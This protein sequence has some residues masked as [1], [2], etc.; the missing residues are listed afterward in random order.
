MQRSVRAEQA[1]LGAVLSDPAG[2]QRVLDWVR[3]GDMRRPYHG[4][5][6]A[7]MQ[8][9]RGGGV[10]PGPH[11]VRR[12]LGNDPDLR[13]EAS[14]RVVYLAELMERSPRDGHA[15]AYAALV[16][17]QAVHDQM[18]LAGSRMAQAAGSGN[19]DGAFVQARRARQELAAARARWE[20][21]PQHLRRDLP[22]P[23]PRDQ[24]GAEIARRAKAVR[25]ELARLRDD[26]WATGGG[27]IQDRLAGIAQQIAETAAL[28]ADR[29]ARRDAAAEARPA[30]REAAAAGAQALRD[31]AA[32]PQQLA[33]VNGWLQPAHFASRE[34][35]ELYR[36]MRDLH[37][38]GKPV[39]AV[40][41]SWEAGRRGVVM[42]PQQIDA[43]LAGGVA[44]A[45][46]P[47]AR[48]AHEHGARAQVAQAGRDI[49]AQAT[50]P[51]SSPPI[52]LRAADKRLCQVEREHAAVRAARLSVSAQPPPDRAAE[53]LPAQRTDP[54]PASPGRA[55]DRP[56]QARHQ[57]AE[58]R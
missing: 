44:A 17:D 48:A 14:D 9:L 33:G 40:T 54:R 57:E 35:G 49:Q 7:A 26:V 42:T 52:L 46:V 24:A 27:E 53:P 3:P 51:A 2:Q 55:G 11:E 56:A 38:A 29:A 1:L 50:D 32:A 10:L 39:D 37:A 13:A 19:L 4:Q 5:V 25:D 34:H 23:G 12:E 28:S 31:L 20:K 21:L 8:R 36:V 18:H 30:G 43:V 47:S 22:A 41:V 15:L 6:L 16:I 58:A 45:A